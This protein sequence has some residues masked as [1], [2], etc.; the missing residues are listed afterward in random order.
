MQRRKLTL[1][2]WWGV[3]SD[4][5]VYMFYIYSFAYLL[6]PTFF[7]ETFIKCLPHSRMGYSLKLYYLIDKGIF[8]LLLVEGA[9]QKRTTI[10]Q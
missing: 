7:P 3:S 5:H 1:K 6:L 2:V 10:K 8:I 9:P 4:I